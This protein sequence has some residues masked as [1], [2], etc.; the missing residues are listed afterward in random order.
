MHWLNIGMQNIT[1]LSADNALNTSAI[2]EG[3][4]VEKPNDHP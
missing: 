2:A 4:D 3:L 1:L